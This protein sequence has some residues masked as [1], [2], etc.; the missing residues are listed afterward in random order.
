MF[1][2]EYDLT[3]ESEGLEKTSLRGHGGADFF[4]MEAFV[5][6][7]QVTITKLISV[8]QDLIEVTCNRYCV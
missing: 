6:A 3:K 8:A 5:S 7:I 4:A 1:T 2:V